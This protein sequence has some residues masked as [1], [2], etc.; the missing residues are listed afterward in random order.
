MFSCDH[1]AQSP[2]VAF[3]FSRI[4]TDQAAFKAEDK[5]KFQNQQDLPKWN[6]ESYLTTSVCPAPSSGDK[7]ELKDTGKV[8]SFDKDESY[9]C[10]EEKLRYS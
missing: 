3:F 1:R 8:I 10:D 6:H 7:S 5:E 2:P 4:P 9:K